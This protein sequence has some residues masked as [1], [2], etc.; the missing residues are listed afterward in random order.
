LCERCDVCLYGL[1]NISNHDGV[2]IYFNFVILCFLHVP[3]LEGLILQESAIKIS[4]L[5]VMYDEKFE[6]KNYM[7][8]IIKKVLQPYKFTIC[9]YNCVSLYLW[10]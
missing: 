7:H 3:S 10:I 6:K 8:V 5:F 4:N 2:I 1:E 9:M